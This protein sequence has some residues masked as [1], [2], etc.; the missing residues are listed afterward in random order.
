[1]GAPASVRGLIGAALLALAIFAGQTGARAQ[2]DG[3]RVYQLTPK[4]AQAWTVFAVAKRGNEEPEVGTVLPG[5]DIDTDLLIPRYVTTLSLGGRQF[6]PFVIIPTGR[7]RFQLN[8]GVTPPASSSGF[9]DLQIGGVVGLVGSPALAP[10][11][12]A[13]FKPG[14]STGLFAKAYFPTGAYSATKA[15]NLGSNRYAFQLGLPTGFAWGTS[16]RAP[17]LTTLDVFPTLTFYDDNDDPYGAD[18]S[19]KATLFSV[20][21]HLTHNLSRT[22]WLSADVLY[23][24]GGETTTD[25]VKGGDA[26]DGWSAG[27]SAAW[28][29]NPRA[30]LILTYQQ[31]I[32][33]DDDGPDGGFF[34][35][36]LV[37][38]F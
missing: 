33:R 2:D 12:Y 7:T 24:R 36:A 1:M 16:Y 25:G 28:V 8:D 13:N 4:G 20:E 18:R 35:A 31:V 37:L 34:R 27:G 17:R 6:A 32:E 29:L 23:R 10:A 9:G 22:T 15:V 5:S 14:F 30:T 21:G 3:P 38:P 11:D 19:S 26:T